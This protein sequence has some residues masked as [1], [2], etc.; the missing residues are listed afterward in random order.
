MA[1]E[2]RSGFTL[3]DVDALIHGQVLDVLWQRMC[4]L[5]TGDWWNTDDSEAFERAFCQREDALAELE[6]TVL[7]TSGAVYQALAEG[8]AARPPLTDDLAEG[9]LVVVFDGLSVREGCFLWEQLRRERYQ[10]EMSYTFSNLP[11][12]TTSFCQK[13][14]GLSSAKA[15]GNRKINGFP[16]AYAADEARVAEE[17]PQGEGGLLWIG[18]PDPLMEGGKKGAKTILEPLEAWRRTWQA[19]TTVLAGAGGREVW[20]TGDHGYIYRGPRYTDRFWS[21][22]DTATGQRL[23]GLFGGG[24]YRADLELDTEQAAAL[25]D[26]VWPHPQGGYAVKGRW[27]WPMPGQTGA[28]LH[29]GLSLVECLVP[30]LK[31]Q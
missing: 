30:I 21:L 20:V 29:E 18:I 16:S 4:A 8:I 27:L 10:V 6:F 17:L 25:R 19:M 26:C 14:F 5:W 22:G 11:A 23:R 2:V 15:L 24:R 13:H 7:Q 3:A 9:R 28:I 12:E 1:N 31:V